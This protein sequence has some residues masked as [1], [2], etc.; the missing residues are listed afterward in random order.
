M[1]NK[2]ESEHRPLVS[3]IV[4]TYN[5]D[6]LATKTVKYLSHFH[7]DSY[8]I[9]VIDQSETSFGELESYCEQNPNKI[10][11][12]KVKEKGLAKARNCGIAHATGEIILFC[13]DDIIPSLNLL[14]AHISNY[15]DPVIG[16]VA[17]RIANKKVDHQ[18]H[19]IGVIQRYT[20][21]Q[22][23]HFDAS[24]RV[25]VDHGQGC[26]LSFRKSIL[27]QV[28]GFD[29]RFAGSAFLEETDVCLRVKKAGYQLLFE[30]K[31]TIIHLKE[32]KGGC[33]SFSSEDWYYWYGHNYSLFFLKHFKK[34]YAPFFL[35]Y[36]LLNIIKGFV[37]FRNP[38]IP[39]YG[40][41]GLIEG[42][43]TYSR[44]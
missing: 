20:A 29:E 24:A 39:I 18:A 1:N 41:K 43:R 31:A 7:F 38:R 27:Q 25:I 5:R 36:R 34:R 3:V 37:D 9:I 30:P 15:A 16:G 42:K 14:Q 21:N 33:R 6:R 35:F 17:G 12:V 26:N 40:L 2:P 22:N 11:Y 13:D 8:E 32:N 44:Q 10:K 4:P 28:G 23:D 19:K